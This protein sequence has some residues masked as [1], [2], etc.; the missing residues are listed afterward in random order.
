MSRHFKFM[1]VMVPNGATQLEDVRK[2]LIK[3]V[4]AEKT[5]AVSFQNN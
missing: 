5:N 3:F 2:I 4:V 1:M